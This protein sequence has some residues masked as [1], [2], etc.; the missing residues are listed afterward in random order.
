VEWTTQ[1]EEG[2]AAGAYGNG[3]DT[4]GNGQETQPLPPQPPLPPQSHPPLPPQP[5][6]PLPEEGLSPPVTTPPAPVPTHSA[7]MTPAQQAASGYEHCPSCGALMAADQRYCLE[8]GH[9]RGEP[10][11]PFMDA[12]VF[13][14]AMNQPPETASASPKARKRG[15]SP[16]A[17]LIAG[18]G[19]LLL[20]LGIGVLI[21]RSG[22]HSAAPASQA[23]IVIHGG[24]GEEV[25]KSSSTGS[26]ETIGGGGSTKG[27][28]KKQIVKEKKK[29]A[30]TGKG[31]E[32]VLHTAPGVNL[33][34]PKI[35]VGE[36]CDKNVAGCNSSGEFDGSYFG[37]E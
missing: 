3:H 23:P 37:E 9:R 4:H 26:S 25:A 16:N 13:M 18:V 10:R 30:E 35:Q 5:H 32:E 8:C 7:P 27:Q 19:T 31:A 14:D 36:K 17:A 22:D 6:P 11:L 1:S 28:S 20:A 21:G 24:T 15:I 2:R 34:P 12:V 29:A 33:P